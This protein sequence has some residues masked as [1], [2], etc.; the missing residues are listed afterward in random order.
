MERK[1]MVQDLAALSATAAVQAR[2]LLVYTDTLGARL[3]G[4]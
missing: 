1:M 4:L 2:T 3:F